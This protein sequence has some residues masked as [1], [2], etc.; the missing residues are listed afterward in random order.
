M[1]NSIFDRT[2]GNVCVDFISLAFFTLMLP[3]IL[4][5][6]IMIV[7][8]ALLLD[9]IP[10]IHSMFN[11]EMRRSRGNWLEENKMLS[12]KEKYLSAKAFD[13]WFV[14]MFSWYFKSIANFL[15]GGDM[16]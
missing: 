8:G 4:L 13:C 14:K 12:A 5:F 9:A 11:R 1:A 16:E 6:G 3:P 2:F 7:L 10:I 15:S